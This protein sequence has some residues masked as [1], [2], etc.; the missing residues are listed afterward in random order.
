MSCHRGAPVVI[1]DL[2]ALRKSTRTTDMRPG[3]REGLRKLEAP[4][5]AARL[6]KTPRNARPSAPP[7]AQTLMNRDLDHR[8]S[9]PSSHTYGL[10][11]TPKLSRPGS[12]RTGWPVFQSTNR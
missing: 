2:E 1:N 8:S 10:Y 4:E 9:L 5:G 12:V 3:P 7:Q 11:T 6:L